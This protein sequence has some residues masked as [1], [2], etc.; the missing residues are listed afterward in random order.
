MDE[1]EFLLPSELRMLKTV[2]STVQ[3]TFARQAGHCPEI[4][5]LLDGA[6]KRIE[7]L[8]VES[9]EYFARVRQLRLE[10]RLAASKASITRLF[11]KKRRR[12]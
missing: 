8:V 6:N 9:E 2:L 7:F 5:G 12:R 3:S 1:I 11:S 10:R 4:L